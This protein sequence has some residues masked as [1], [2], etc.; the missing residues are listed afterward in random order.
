MFLIISILIKI[1][2]TGPVFF[3]SK[4]AGHNGN[5][6]NMIKFRTM[7]VNTE[8]VETSQ[9][10]NPSAK[11]TKIGKTLRKYS[12]DEIPQFICVLF[13]S[14]SIVG[15]RPALSSQHDLLEKRKELG[16]HILKPGITGYAQI[17]GRDFMSTDQKIAFEYDYLKNKSLLLDL[18]II[19][20]TIKVVVTQKG[21]SH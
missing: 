15:P 20:K 14:M 6:F 18:K 4:R 12:F 1:D 3:I 11:I 7:F 16:I 8:T 10:K 2:S 5:E 17:N 19:V 9:L 13:G 21:V